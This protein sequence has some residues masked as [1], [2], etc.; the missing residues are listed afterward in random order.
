MFHGIVLGWELSAPS[1]VY[2][3][4]GRGRRYSGSRTNHRRCLAF[5][6]DESWLRFDS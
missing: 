3:M 4:M 6:V 1:F 5:S 2:V